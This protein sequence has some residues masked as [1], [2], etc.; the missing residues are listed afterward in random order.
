MYRE[1]IKPFAVVFVAVVIAIIII[2]IIS[3]SSSSSSS[4]VVVVV[5]VIIITI[6]IVLIRPPRISAQSNKYG[7]WFLR[8]AKF[9]ISSPRGVGGGGL[10]TFLGRGCLSNNFNGTP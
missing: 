2:I 6:I 9:R 1:P 3:S 5:V 10:P 4:I 8:E 7:I